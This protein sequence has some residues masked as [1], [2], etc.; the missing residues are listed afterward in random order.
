MT[1]TCFSLVNTL[2]QK[3]NADFDQV[4]TLAQ[5]QLST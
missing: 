4:L 5:D 2:N 3:V 1:V